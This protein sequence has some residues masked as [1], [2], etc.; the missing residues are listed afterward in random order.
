MRR[1]KEWTGGF[2]RFRK[3]LGLLAVMG[4]MIVLT[5]VVV[6]SSPY[7]PVAVEAPPI[8]EIWALEDARKESETPLVTRLENGGMPLAYDAENRIFYCT[9]GLDNGEDWPKL[10]LTAPDA[11]G[12]K[13]VFTDD[14]RYDACADALADGCRYQMMAYDDRA[15]SYFDIVFTGL[16]TLTLHT[17]AEIGPEDVCG[18][19]ELSVYGEEPLETFIRTHRRG[20]ANYDAEKAGYKVHYTRKPNG[21]KKLLLPTPGLGTTSSL[22]LLPMPG[23]E[24]LMRDRLSWSVYS[25]LVPQT[26]S[27]G[28]RES[29]YA[30]VFVNGSYRG[31]YLLL[32]PYDMGQELSKH[33]ERHMMTD[34]VYR[35]SAPFFIWGREHIPDPSDPDL[36]YEL[37]Y[38]PDGKKP[39][40][41][42]E[43]YFDLMQEEDDAVFLEK[44]K[45]LI[46]LPSALRMALMIQA[47]G[48][49]DNVCNNLFIWAE[50]TSGGWRYHF[51]PWDMDLSWGMRRDYIGA[52]YDRWL[53]FPLV[54]RLLRLDADVREAYGQMYESMRETVFSEALIAERVA[55]YA[56]E[57]AASGAGER[58]RALWRP[59]G[60]TSEGWELIEFAG[61]RLAVLDEVIPWIVSGE[62]AEAP[63][64]KQTA[65]DC[66]GAAIGFTD[67]AAISGEKQENII[68]K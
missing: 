24:S 9:L 22:V 26:E 68:V 60:Q 54:D 42:L 65:Y 62:G 66:R 53:F 23:D 27:F 61:M 4:L 11:G 19:M 36:V 57:L 28:A 41:P 59:E 3:G 16:P 2:W 32:P 14:Y 18:R 44:A 25:G 33:G 31:V 38:T 47:G 45:R 51:M 15:Y 35:V 50:K 1:N 39:F 49:V 40:R 12:V 56:G 5:G 48:M 17:E 10:H 52:E 21:H 34:S 63:F 7:Q 43:P 6:F 46:D 29:R 55:Q 37:F 67:E 13:L 30:E 8:E 58:N 20:G 64:L